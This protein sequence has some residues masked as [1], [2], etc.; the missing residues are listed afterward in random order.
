MRKLLVYPA[1]L[2]T[3]LLTACSG[4]GTTSQGSGGSGLVARNRAPV[5]VA[6]PDQTVQ[7]GGTALLDGSKSS[8]P[9]GDSL[10]YQWTIS[11]KPAGSNTS[12]SDAASAQ[13]SLSP[14]VKGII[15]SSLESLTVAVCRPPIRLLL[16][17]QIALQW[18]TREAVRQSL[19]VQEQ[20]LMAPEAG[21]QTETS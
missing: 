21:I 5:A 1:I 18:Q 14:D 11:T 12:L 6:G 19:L 13:T 20:R 3:A 9:D 4:G 7:V 16:P 2:M 8:D 10:T 17:S 15:A